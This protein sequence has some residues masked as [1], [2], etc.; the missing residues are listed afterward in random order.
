MPLRARRIA[1]ELESSPKARA[2]FIDPQD[3]IAR[4]RNVVSTEAVGI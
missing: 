3:H 2:A 4:D 1:S